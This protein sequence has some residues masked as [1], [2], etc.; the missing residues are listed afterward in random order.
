MIDSV[1]SLVQGLANTQQQAGLLA[2]RLAADS[3]RQIAD[4]LMQHAVAPAP[5]ANPP[6][7]GQQVD[8]YA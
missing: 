8:T 2:L 4:V 7:L 6:G 3:Q 1:S 5:S